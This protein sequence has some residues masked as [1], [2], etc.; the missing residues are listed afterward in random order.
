MSARPP[1]GDAC[2]ARRRPQPILG[3]AGDGDDSLDPEAILYGALL[4]SNRPRPL[5]PPESKTKTSPLN[6]LDRFRC[7]QQGQG[8]KFC[9]T[10]ELDVSSDPQGW[11]YSFSQRPT[12]PGAKSGKA[13]AWT[14]NRQSVKRHRK[15]SQAKGR[16][17]EL[18]EDFLAEP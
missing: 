14:V 5:L 2:R 10:T 15:Q 11:F 13:K 1:H 16:A 18:Y 17:L 12:G 7:L 8:P 6:R 9:W 4:P 3:F